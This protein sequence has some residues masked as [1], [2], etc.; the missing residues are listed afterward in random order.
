M[1]SFATA[2]T[3]DEHR[4]ALDALTAGQVDPPDNRAGLLHELDDVN[5]GTDVDALSPVAAGQEIGKAGA[6]N[7]SE[8]AGFSLEDRH[9]DPVGACVCGDLKADVPAANDDQPATTL[10]GSTQVTRVV[11]GTQRQ[12]SRPIG[13]GYRQRTRARTGGE[14]EILVSDAFAG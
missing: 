13:P 9:L 11:K 2:P 8:H 6:G 3:P 10:Y 7:T 4:V 14:H 5:R 12:D 1:S